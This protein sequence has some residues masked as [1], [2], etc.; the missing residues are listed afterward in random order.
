M[1]A[2]VARWLI[3]GLALGVPTAAGAQTTSPQEPP[4]PDVMSRQID[5]TMRQ[6]CSKV[7]SF[8]VQALGKTMCLTMKSTGEWENARR[9]RVASLK[10]VGLT[11]GLLANERGQNAQRSDAQSR[12]T[13]TVQ[14]LVEAGQGL[15]I[16]VS[17]TALSRHVEA[18]RTQ[19]YRLN[20]ATVTNAEYLVDASIAR[21]ASPD[22]EAAQLLMVRSIATNAA[23]DSAITQAQAGIEARERVL[24]S[25]G[26]RGAEAARLE[27]EIRTMQTYL[28][29]AVSAARAQHN[30]MR[31]YVTLREEM[32]WQLTRS[33]SVVRRELR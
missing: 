27:A 31:A 5:R 26:A 14:G 23:L 15:A 24:R 6:S 29:G 18:S 12:L 10:A 21:P 19:E 17:P 22:D 25:G 20:T 16:A 8:A 32:K 28:A 7:F 3:L 33:P 1:R 13:R 30:E 4:S 9:F 2:P 11:L